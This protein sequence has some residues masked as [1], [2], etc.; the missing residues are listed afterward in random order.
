VEKDAYLKKL[1]AAARNLLRADCCGAP[2]YK[3]NVRL[4]V[5]QHCKKYFVDAFN[6]CQMLEQGDKK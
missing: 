3:Y 6:L 1:E 5:C 2:G 4:H